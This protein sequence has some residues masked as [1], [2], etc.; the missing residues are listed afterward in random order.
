MA[1]SRTFSPFAKSG[2]KS[3]ALM[4]LDRDYYH[5]LS[6]KELLLLSRLAVLTNN[7]TTPCNYTNE[8]GKKEFNFPASSLERTFSNLKKLKLI[9]L[10]RGYALNR[11]RGRLVRLIS[12]CG[13]PVVFAGK[14]GA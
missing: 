9:D 1:V 13:T 11:N 5:F 10:S 12:L 8:Q 4:N 6:D 3:P 2:K 14:K 7:G